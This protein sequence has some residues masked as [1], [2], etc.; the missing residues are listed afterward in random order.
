MTTP[1]QRN[2]ALAV[3]KKGKT[4]ATRYFPRFETPNGQIDWEII[5]AW[6]QEL[7]TRNY[8]PQLW[9]KAVSHWVN[10]LAQ[11]GD[12]ATTGDILKAAKQVWATWAE[13]PATADYVENYRL[14]AL[15]RKYQRTVK[16]Y[17]PGSVFPT[18]EEQR[19]ELAN[20][21]I[22][23]LKTRLAQTRKAIR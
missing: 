23:E 4:I 20:P 3:L 10:H 15:D 22:Q 17:K 9:D 18:P 6:A 19:P 8:P 5:D 2:I 13:D 1:H 12:V 11:S 7:A 14:T 16:G 21:N